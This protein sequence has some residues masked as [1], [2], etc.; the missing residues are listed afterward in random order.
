MICQSC[1]NIF[2]SEISL[3]DYQTD[4]R[5]LDCI[6]F[7]YSK[8][9]I[10]TT[11]LIDHQSLIKAYTDFPFTRIAI[12]QPNFPFTRFPNTFVIQ[13]DSIK[14]SMLDLIKKCEYLNLLG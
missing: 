12:T 10:V 2:T 14:S 3:P 8:Y 9:L 11:T 4:C 13:T 7:D 1:I 6:I 5:N